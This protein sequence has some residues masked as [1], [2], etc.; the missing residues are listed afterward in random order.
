MKN[1]TNSPLPNY[2]LIQQEISRYC[3]TTTWFS[4]SPSQC[5]TVLTTELL[6][7]LSDLTGQP[8]PWLI[9]E[10]VRNSFSLELINSICQSKKLNSRFKTEQ[11]CSKHL[12]KDIRTKK[13]WMSL[14]DV[15][16][17]RE[18]MIHNQLVVLENWA[19]VIE[20]HTFSFYDKIKRLSKLADDPRVTTICEIGYNFGHSVSSLFSSLFHVILIF[21]SSFCRQSIG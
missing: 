6:L 17:L 12:E 20:G 14:Y 19:D 16:P 21:L 4:S 11:E 9:N 10:V 13:V 18:H 3:S 1:N 2:K 7:K 15:L 8:S 5:Q